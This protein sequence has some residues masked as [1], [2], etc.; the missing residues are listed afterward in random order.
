MTELEV[1]QAVRLKGRV[2]LAELARTV[3]EDLP[4]VAST[5]AR[6]AEAGYLSQA[7]HSSSAPLGG[8]A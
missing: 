1:L 3:G 6:L 8:S 4:L 2:N 5:V 7:I